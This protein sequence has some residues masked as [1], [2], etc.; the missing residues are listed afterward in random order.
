M[1]DN[2]MK[3]NEEG[4]I[5]KEWKDLINWEDGNGAGCFVSD[6]ISKEGWKVGYMYREEP[7]KN[8]PDSGWRFLKGDESDE[9]VNDSKNVHIL[10]INTVCN[11]DPDIIPYLNSLYGSAYIRINEKEFQLDDN[12]KPIYTTKQDDFKDEK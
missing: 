12:T 2:K 3:R 5:Q 10:A 11:L 8:A 1:A 9:Y 6:K 7:D 4:F